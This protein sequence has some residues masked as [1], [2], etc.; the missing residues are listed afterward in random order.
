MFGGPE[1]SYHQTH[2]ARDWLSVLRTL[3]TT[4]NLQVQRRTDLHMTT[5]ARNRTKNTGLMKTGVWNVRGLYGKEN[6]L[7]E[8]LKKANVDIA[9][10]LKQKRN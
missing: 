1:V 7:Q 8:E 2:S 3:Y 9:V 4:Q 5:K 10:Y 6:L